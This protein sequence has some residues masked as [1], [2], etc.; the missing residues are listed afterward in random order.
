MRPI[1]SSTERGLEEAVAPAALRLGERDAEH[2]RVG[3]L[4]PQLAVEV[5]V[6]ALDLLQTLVGELTLEDL[7]G[8]TLQVLLFLR[9]GEVHLIRSVRYRGAS[10]M[11]RPNTAIRSRCTSFTPPPNVR[12]IRPR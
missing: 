11:P 8:Q 9:E 5:L 3:E 10:G 4:R 7:R 12:M 6:A 1:C 2:A